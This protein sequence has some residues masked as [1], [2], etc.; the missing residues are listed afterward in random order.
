ML[1]DFKKVH[2][3]TFYGNE[4]VQ[5]AKFYSNLLYILY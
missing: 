3:K 4:V 1:N 5:C 2:A